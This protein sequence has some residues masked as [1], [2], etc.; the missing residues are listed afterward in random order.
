MPIVANTLNVSSWIVNSKRPNEE[1]IMPKNK[2]ENIQ[3]ILKYFSSKNP[4]PSEK[5]K[6]TA[7]KRKTSSTA[8]NLREPRFSGAAGL[9]EMGKLSFGTPSDYPPKELK[10]ALK[11][12]LLRLN[13]TLKID[14]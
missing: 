12:F 9:N 7:I 1:K 4:S 5:A 13:Q 6:V 2:A 8:M 14:L 3:G 10:V 11:T